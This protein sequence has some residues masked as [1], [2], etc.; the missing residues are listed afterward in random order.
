MIQSYGSSTTNHFESSSIEYHQHI[1]ICGL[2]ELSLLI[3][4]FGTSALLLLQDSCNSLIDTLF[5]VIINPSYSVR[6]SAAWCFRSIGIALPSLMTPL[7]DKCFEKL[8]D[9]AKQPNS[10]NTDAMSGFALA[11]QALLGAVHQCPLGK[12]VINLFFSSNRKCIKTK[13]T[14]FN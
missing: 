6:L 12:S 1:L 9:L 4:S 3:E 5:L 7:I 13:L 2:H 10:C 11:L 14:F 8:N